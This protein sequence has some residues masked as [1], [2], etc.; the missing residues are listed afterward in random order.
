MNKVFCI[1][2]YHLP[3]TQIRCLSQRC[4]L[5]TIPLVS[6]VLITMVHT[7][8]HTSCQSGVDHNGAHS[9]PYLLSVRCWS[10]R[11]T[12]CTIPLVS[13]VLITTVH[14]LYHTSCHQQ[15]AHSL[16]R[17][18]KYSVFCIIIFLVHRSSGYSNITHC[19]PF[20]LSPTLSP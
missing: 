13:Q 5:C 15:W 20:L 10:Q 16:L 8:Y 7:L 6:Q 19:V 18:I 11:C 4:T 14:T 12:L 9:V 17:W 2:Y 1:L 3:G